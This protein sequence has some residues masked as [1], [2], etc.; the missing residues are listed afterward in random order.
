M[1]T[2]TVCGSESFLAFNNVVTINIKYGEKKLTSKSATSLKVT[3][4]IINHMYCIHRQGHLFS[5]ATLPQKKS[6]LISDVV[7]GVC[8]SEEH[9]H[10]QR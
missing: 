4:L 9:T 7:M 3:V 1:K 2:K 5:F 6:H 10:S 8:A